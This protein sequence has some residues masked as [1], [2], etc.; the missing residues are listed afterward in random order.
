MISPELFYEQELKGKDF[1]TVSSVIRKLKREIA[2]LKRVMEHP[3]Y[4]CDC[5]SKPDEMTRLFCMR[6]YLQTAKDTLAELGVPYEATIFEKRI[7][8]FDANICN[9]SR[10]TLDIGGFFEGWQNYTICVGKQFVYRAEDTGIMDDT[11]TKE[12]FLSEFS[13]LNIGEWRRYYHTKRFG[14]VVCDGTQWELKIDYTNGRKPF[15]SG[16]SNAY[17]Y[18]F[19]ALCDLLCVECAV[20]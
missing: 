19:K 6:L 17:P 18:N 7:A 3:G 8:D 20:D 11:V 16:G 4:E 5:T 14:F 9:I 2:K 10:I 13:V 12:E 15:T 1:N